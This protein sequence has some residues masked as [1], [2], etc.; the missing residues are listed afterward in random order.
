MK[1]NVSQ[2][3][4][5]IYLL[6]QCFGSLNAQNS[7]FKNN[8]KYAQIRMGYVVDKELP[9]FKGF[10]LFNVGYRF[11]NDNIVQNFEFEYIPFS[12]TQTIIDSNFPNEIV[13]G[14]KIDY[15]TYE[16]IYMYGYLLSKSRHELSAGP[17]VSLRFVDYI[18]EPFNEN[19]FPISNLCVCSG[20]GLNLGYAV[21]ITKRMDFSLSSR[22]TLFDIGYAS[23]YIENPVLP[24][25]LRRRSNFSVEVIRKTY[26]LSFGLR[27]L[28]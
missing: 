11:H 23:Q 2:K 19:S 18:Q 12:S 27:F 26:H 16:F 8:A 1:P 17:T 21:K 15:K 20:I 7:T 3:I 13:G 24:E 4:I 28:L 10:N 25:S 6:I 9:T 22:I 14:L 5:F